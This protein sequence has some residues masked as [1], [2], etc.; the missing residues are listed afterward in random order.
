[1][2]TSKPRLQVRAPRNPD[3]FVAGAK[4]AEALP[5]RGRVKRANGV[6]LDRITIYLTEEVGAKLRRYC[7]DNKL[8]LSDVAGGAV[9]AFVEKL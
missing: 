4:P 6:T 2:S 9:T 7:F 3:A 1:M 5:A 8:E